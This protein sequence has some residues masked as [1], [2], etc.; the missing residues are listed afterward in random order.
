MIHSVAKSSSPGAV[1][2]IL[3]SKPFVSGM[4]HG[5][6]FSRSLRKMISE[7]N[8]LDPKSRNEKDTAG[9]QYTVEF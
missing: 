4:N 6:K 8:R 1:V 2:K 9:K 5:R 7:L 3:N